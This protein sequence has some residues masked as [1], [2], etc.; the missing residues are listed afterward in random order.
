MR[1]LL[2]IVGDEGRDEHL[3]ELTAMARPRR[4]T[5]LIENAAREWAWDDSAA[6]LELRDRLAR[7]LESI[8]RRTN[9]VVIGLAGSR[10]QLFGWRFDT[11]AGDDRLPAAA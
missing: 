9:A 10:E 7:L 6:G 3:L 8:E 1:D 4:V 11:V 2:L 5:V